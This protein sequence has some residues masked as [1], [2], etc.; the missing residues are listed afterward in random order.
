MA[1]K[2]QKINIFS[3]KESKSLKRHK[4][5]RNKHNDSKK[6]QGQGR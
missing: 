2:T 1:S 5:K 6:Y 4:K 3:P